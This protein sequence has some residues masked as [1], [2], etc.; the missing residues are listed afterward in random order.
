MRQN[1]SY[2]I[3]LICFLLTLPALNPWVRGDGVGYYAYVRAV[4]ISHNLDFEHDWLRANPSFR[5]NRVDAS[6]HLLPMNYTATNHINNHF[7]PGPALLWF[8]FVALTHMG[9][10]AANHLGTHIP[11]DGFSRPYVVAMG[12][13]TAVYGFLG[14]CLSFSVA[15]KYVEERWALLA[16]L[17]IWFASSLPVYMYLNPS[18]SHALSAFTVALYFWY[19]DRTRPD[20]SAVQWIVLGLI[21]GL[22][23]DVY[24][25]N[26]SLL[27]VIGVEAIFAIRKAVSERGL[28]AKIPT[29][30]VNYI[31]YLASLVVALA[32]IFVT[33]YVIFGSAVDSGYTEQWFWAHPK[34]L[35]VLFSAN[36]GLFSWTP[37]LALA[38]LGLGLLA[39]Q[40]RLLAA[41]SC[42]AFVCFL[43][44][45]AS[46]Q[47][48][49]GISSFGSRFFVSLTVFFVLGLASAT[50]SFA[51]LFSSQ[52]RALISVVAV[53]FL[54]VAWNGG[55]L[56]QWG[57]H[58]LPVRG[59][60]SWSAVARN[61]F[62]VVPRMMVRT[63]RSYLFRR[64]DLMRQIENRDL[65]Q[66]RQQDTE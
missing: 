35:S 65:E 66:L 44:L 33:H 54:F 56:F 59:P 4:V 46:Y 16:T 41:C 13:A 20:R 42:S 64:S 38:V 23:L 57:M 48:W 5:L 21:S 51:N 45:I 24:Y 2:K 15:R 11:P 3:L 28:N 18:W 7:S 47:D 49:H 22:M 37:I 17:G 30:A 62:S 25:A 34:V 52:R 40:D 39:K 31:M 43:Y 10:L 32:P 58:L 29:F 12:L 63:S 61:Q 26:A 53:L 8:P 60:V 55:L 1:L 6:G 50:A 14:I 27:V 19:W 9:V 36:H